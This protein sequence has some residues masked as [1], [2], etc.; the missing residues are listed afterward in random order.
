MTIMTIKKYIFSAVPNQNNRDEQRWGSEV[1]LRRALS[2]GISRIFAKIP[3]SESP[4]VV[5]SWRQR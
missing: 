3:P 5:V 4:K 2:P 1:Y